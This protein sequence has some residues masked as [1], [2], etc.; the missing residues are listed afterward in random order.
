MSCNY[1]TERKCRDWR[2]FLRWCD[3]IVKCGHRRAESH[4][5]GS[6]GQLNHSTSARRH[7]RHKQR[8]TWIPPEGRSGDVVNRSFV[9]SRWHHESADWLEPVWQRISG[10]VLRP[11]WSNANCHNGRDSQ[12]DSNRW[13]HSHKADHFSSC[14][15]LLNPLL[16]GKPRV[17]FT[18]L[19]YWRHHRQNR[20][21][22]KKPLWLW[23]DNDWVDTL[24][25]RRSH[26]S[27]NTV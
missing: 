10:G 17:R 3:L 21:F 23:P 19:L 8:R 6:I 15:L 22:T 16:R 24:E 25:S 1:F 27:P 18:G 7:G 26:Y 20:V 5:A 2:L 9:W 4:R 11:R 13:H 12:W 14:D